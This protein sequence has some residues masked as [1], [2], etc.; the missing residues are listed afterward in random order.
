MIATIPRI[1][2]GVNM[3]RKKSRPAAPT[4]DTLEHATEACVT[5]RYR[6]R[7]GLLLKH[8]ESC[9][10]F[11]TDKVIPLTNNEAEHS[12]RSYILWR[13]GSYGVYSHRGEQFRQRILTIVESCRKLGA[14]PL[15]WL[16]QIVHAVITRS[17]YPAL[18]ELTAL[19]Q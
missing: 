6:N 1:W 2:H 3:T 7:C 18:P 11:L 14:N 16:R 19:S 10:T 12:L 13:K 8:D 17:E 4:A 15:D 9:W 5:P